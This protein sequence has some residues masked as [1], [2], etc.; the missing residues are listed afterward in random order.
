MVDNKYM[1]ARQ[2]DYT[3]ILNPPKRMLDE[4]ALEFAAWIVAMSPPAL[5]DE[6]AKILNEV[7]N[8]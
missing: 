8:T 7:Q 1:V 6:F 2:G 4:D 3:V 5:Q